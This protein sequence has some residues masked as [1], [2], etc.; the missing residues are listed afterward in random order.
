MHFFTEQRYKLISSSATTIDTLLLP[1]SNRI[2]KYI[3][4]DF[5]KVK[6]KNDSILELMNSSTKGF[7]YYVFRPLAGLN[8]LSNTLNKW[9]AT[10]SHNSLMSIN[11]FLLKRLNKRQERFENYFLLFEKDINNDWVFSLENRKIIN[12]IMVYMADTL[13]TIKDIPV[14][15]SIRY[16]KAYGK[17][18][19]HSRKSKEIKMIETNDFLRD[20]LKKLKTYSMFA[21][22]VYGA[23]LP[24]TISEAD[25]GKLMKST[26][27][28]DRFKMFTGLSDEQ[29]IT[30]DDQANQFMPGYSIVLSHELQSIVLAIRGTAELFDVVADLDGDEL[31][32][33]LVDPVTGDTLA[34]GEV[35]RGI[36]RCAQNIDS[37]VKPKILELLNQYTDYSLNI[38]GHSLGGGAT[39]LLSL[40]WLFDREIM[41]RG[42]SAAAYAPPPVVDKTLNGYLKQVLFSVSNGDDVVTRLSEGAIKDLAGAV[43]YFYDKDHCESF[44]SAKAKSIREESPQDRLF[45]EEY[46]K[47]SKILNNPKLETPGNVVLMMRRGLHGGFDLM[48]QDA[49]VAWSFVDNACFEEII[50]TKRM[51]K[52]HG[53]ED[54]FN[55]LI[56]IKD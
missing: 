24:S 29:I 26:S 13:G 51:V 53:S 16:L 37:A 31:R 5:D 38:C 2:H 41:K 39:A 52:D 7:L 30:F 48:K 12:Q 11:S 49:E 55:H 10:K 21:V 34:E 40:I 15:T 28:R 4:A 33:P 6:E 32:V 56:L 17:L 45:T 9:L 36:Y 22:G 35:H 50:L 20:G 47:V 14:I 1:L 27:K 43:K 25:K 42:F 23:I 54:Y 3:L 8:H 46:G 19:K 18:Q 44:S